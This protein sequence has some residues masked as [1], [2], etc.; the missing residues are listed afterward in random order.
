MSRIVIIILDYTT[1]NGMT[2]KN[3]AEQIQEEMGMA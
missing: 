2:D 1:L 3:K